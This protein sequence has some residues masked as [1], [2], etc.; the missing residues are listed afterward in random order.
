MTTK[1]KTEKTD[2]SVTPAN[3]DSPKPARQSKKT[4]DSSPKSTPRPRTTRRAV[5]SPKRRP[6]A[7]ELPVAATT[8]AAT[9]APSPDSLSILMISPEAH[10]HAKTGGLAEVAGALPNALAALGHTV[11]LVLPRYRRIDTAG[12]SSTRFAMTLGGK[13]Q[14]VTIYERPLNERVTLALVDAPELFDREE[15]YGTSAGDYPDN[16]WRFAVFSRAALEY[17]RI[18]GRRPSVIHAHDW[19]TALVPVYQ[20][21]HLSN[22]PTVGGVP[23]VFTIHNLAFQ[24]IFPRSTISDIGLGPEVLHINAMEYWGHVNYLKAGINFSEKITTV[25]RGYAREIVRPDLGFGLD[26]VIARRAADLVGILNG[27]DVTR[28]NPSADPF[29][30]ASFDDNDLSGKRQ[31]KKALLD[32]VGLPTDEASLARPLIGLVSRL[33]DQKGFDLIAAAA[34]DLMALDATWVMLGSGESRYEDQWRRLAMRYTMR[35]SATIGFDERLAHLIEAGSDLFLMPSRFE[36]C[37]LNQMYSLRYGTVPIVRAT[38][39]LD[40]TVENFD[41][42][43]GRG[44]GFKFAE[45]STHALVATVRRALEVFGN[46]SV[47]AEI[48]R[49]G[50]KQDHSWDASAREY[51]KVYRAAEWR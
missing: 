2:K 37:G 14:T 51:V 8:P 17:A 26:G 38:G 36:P 48:Q 41:D 1:K 10:P 31:A 28:W 25:S 6:V 40:D 29:V 46:P 24:G 18:K 20:K 39:G 50:M 35:V 5:T 33:T 19:Q 16:A 43:T 15:L 30:P 44:S 21:M 27:I 49:S 3:A 34:D 23:T 4:A 11:T 12:A 47:W 9:P 45:Y 13:I 7:P 22:D 32:H 42:T